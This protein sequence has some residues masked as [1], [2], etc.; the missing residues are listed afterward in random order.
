[1]SNDFN[2]DEGI[3]E[4]CVFQIVGCNVKLPE[5]R[6]LEHE[7]ICIYKDRMR[8]YDLNA[9]LESLN[10]H[11]DNDSD[12]GGD[13]EEM[14][15]CKFKDYGCMVKMPRRK[16]Q[17]HVE[18]CNYSKYHD[19]SDENEFRSV[20]EPDVDLD[21]P[22]PCCWSEYGCRVQPKLYRKETHEENCNYRRENC[23]FCE[24]GCPE[25]VE[26]PRRYVHEQRCKYAC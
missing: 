12:D 24:F 6:R 8:D 10:I 25:M 15:E 22:V 3:P 1:M 26:P 2:N 4:H 21:E 23:R 9:N 17:S 14:V 7:K 11:D 5:W 19:G 18:Q 20:S 16:R 13:P